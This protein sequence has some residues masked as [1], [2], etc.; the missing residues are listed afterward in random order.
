MRPRVT[1]TVLATA[2]G[3]LLLIAPPAAEGRSGQL[4]ACRSQPTV[5]LHFERLPAKQAGC[6]SRQVACPFARS[7]PGAGDQLTVTTRLLR[8]KA[9]ARGSDNTRFRSTLARAGAGKTG[10]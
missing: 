10:Q 1:G 2:I 7:E 4:F 8:W 3:L 5:H 6:N 9:L